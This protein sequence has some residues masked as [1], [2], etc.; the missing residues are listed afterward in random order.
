VNR[1]ARGGGRDPLEEA[2]ETIAQQAEEIASLRRR[3][4]EESTASELRA[5]LT[6]AAVARAIASP[7]SHADLLEMIV[8]TAAHVI[9]ADAAALF[10]ID[11]ERQELSFE[12]VLGGGGEAVKRFRLSMGHGIPGLVAVSGQPIAVS[13]AQNDPRQAA[14]IAEAVGYQPQTILCVPLSYNDQIIGVLE[15]LDKEGGATF[16]PADMETLGLFANL[17]AVAIEES[18]THQNLAALLGDILKRADGT[19]A[20]GQPGASER[21]RAL[22]LDLEESAVYRQALELARLVQEIAWQG[23]HEFEACHT[24]LRGLATYVQ[25]RSQRLDD[26]GAFR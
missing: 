26:L 4:T 12:V 17:A 14:D 5:I 6:Q 3:L 20:S 7:V 18:R 21:V 13:D 22:A 10:L 8:A 9:A 24:L 16:S 2:R 1:D 19:G 15:L 23:E 25:A 11:H